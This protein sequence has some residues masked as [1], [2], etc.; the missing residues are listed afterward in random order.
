MYW[1]HFSREALLGAPI[2]RRVLEQ[3]SERPP[4]V[5]PPLF[6]V[7]TARELEVL[8]LIARRLKNREIAEKLVISERTV[9]N[10]VSSIF[11]KLQVA[12][13]VQAIIRARDAVLGRESP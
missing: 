2:A 3:F 10:H 6:D 4:T 7:L 12:D 8:G 1:Q 11:A 13:R 9:G 5:T